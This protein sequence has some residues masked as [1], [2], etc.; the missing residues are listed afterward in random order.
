MLIMPATRMPCGPILA[1]SDITFNQVDGARPGS[2]PSMINTSANAVNRSLPM[3]VP[4]LQWVFHLSASS[5]VR[6]VR[7]NRKTR[8]PDQ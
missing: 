1:A 2:R 7:N 8:N 4:Q 5:R 3:V 6:P